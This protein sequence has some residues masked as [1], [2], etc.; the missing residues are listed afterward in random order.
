[1]TNAARVL[2]IAGELVVQQTILEDRPHSEPAKD[3][4]RDGQRPRRPEQQRE[5]RSQKPE[6][7]VPGMANETVGTS[8]DDALPSVQLNTDGALEEWIHAHRT[9]AQRQA[10]GEQGASE[11]ERPEWQGAVV[12]RA[13]TSERS[14]DPGESDQRRRD[15]L[16]GSFHGD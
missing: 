4:E 9:R 8:V 12:E 11:R 2:A 15:P 6:A 13:R 3:R 1:M 10:A 5:A 14:N 16:K 7:G